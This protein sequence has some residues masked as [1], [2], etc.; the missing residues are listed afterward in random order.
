MMK[1]AAAEQGEGTN[2]ASIA[3]TPFR[4]HQPDEVDDSGAEPLAA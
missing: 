2:A 3:E 1:Q 4:F